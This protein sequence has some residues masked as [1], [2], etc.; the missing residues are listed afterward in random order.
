MHLP[1]L[2]ITAL[3]LQLANAC[4]Q[5]ESSVILMAV[6]RG[7]STHFPGDLQVEFNNEVNKDSSAAGGYNKALKI[8]AASGL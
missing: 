4:K 7:L 6:N 5:W 3:Q 1:G 2:V 8:G